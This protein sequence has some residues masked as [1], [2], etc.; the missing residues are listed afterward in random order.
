MYI[1]AIPQRITGKLSP[2]SHIIGDTD[3]KYKKRR[4]DH[5]S[6]L[7]EKNTKKTQC[8]YPKQP[9][10]DLFSNHTTIKWDTHDNG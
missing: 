3:I 2:Q 8:S 5:G 9:V 6:K 10:S 4:W 1:D 7:I